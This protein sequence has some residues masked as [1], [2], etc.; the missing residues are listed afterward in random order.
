MNEE[1]DRRIKLLLEQGVSKLRIAEELSIT[2][3]TVSRVAARLGYPSQRRQSDGRDWG[4]IR[5]FYEAGHTAAE[6][7]REFGFGAST[8]RA[9]IARGEITPRRRNYAEKPNGETRAA[10]ERLNGDGLG[11][12]EI[13]DELGVSRPT[14]CYHLRKL[15][16]PAQQKFARRHNWDAIAQAYESG[17]SMR[18]CK[19]HFGFS[20]QSWYDAVDRGD[21]VPRDHRIPLEDLL[22]VGRRTSRG[23]LKARLIAAGLKENRCEICGITEWLGKPLST[24]LH[25]KNGDGADNRLINLSLLCPNCHS[26]TDTYGGRNGHRRSER[27]LKLVEPTDDDQEDV[28]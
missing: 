5:V 10:V 11:V 27:H 25:H 26:Q 20:S 24:Q 9:A 13:A 8:W 16:I 12:A 14:V 17:M 3:Q 23:H 4:E 6:T 22:V 2:R 18:E 1:R 28:A 15:G 19:K 21:I 7:Q